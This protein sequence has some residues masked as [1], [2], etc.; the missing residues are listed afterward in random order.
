M[1]TSKGAE[2]RQANARLE[3]EMEARKAKGPSSTVFKHSNGMD[4]SSKADIGGRA[5]SG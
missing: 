4:M 2:G 5:W 3:I 1:A